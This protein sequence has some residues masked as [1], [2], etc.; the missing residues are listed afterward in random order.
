M[1]KWRL[2][3]T[4]AGEGAFNM[5]V[6]EAI[7]ASYREGR[8]PPTIRI[9]GWRP[10][11]ISLGVGQKILDV[12]DVAR[13]GKDD[14]AIVRRMTGGEAIFHG[15]DLSYSIACSDEDLALGG[16]IKESF[17]TLASFIIDI[18]RQK[19]KDACFFSD[20][21]GGGGGIGTRAP[22]TQ[23]CFA[24]KQD[25]DIAVMGRKLGG[26]AQKRMR[27]LIFQHGSIPLRLDI[28]KAQNYFLMDLRKAREGMTTIEEIFGP[29]Y[30]SDA[31]AKDMAESFKKRFGV[32][33]EQSTLTVT[34]ADSAKAL[35]KEKYG[36][37]QWN[38][39]L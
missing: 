25:F 19:G 21:N 17:R 34:E 36:S 12:C 6:D 15:D 8:V 14:V 28:D 20:L 2:I 11:T 29:R 26:N 38:R 16:S 18:Y 22:K 33:L 35:V 3:I 9:Y 30:T 39:R 32:D 1:K 37:D 7:L 24:A 4:G 23:F 31:L 13:S 27:H 5:A 10:H